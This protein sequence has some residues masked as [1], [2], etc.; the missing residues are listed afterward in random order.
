MLPLKRRLSSLCACV[1]GMTIA[2]GCVHVAP[3]ERTKLADPTMAKEDLDGPAA[4][5]VLE[6]HE[7]ATGGGS[8]G[9]SGC[10]CN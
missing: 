2:A 4:A 10:G 7:G 9:A 6:V 8:P 5:H 1:V 3:Y